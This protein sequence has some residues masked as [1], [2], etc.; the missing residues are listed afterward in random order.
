MT[1]IDSLLENFLV[2]KIPPL[3]STIKKEKSSWFRK[4]CKQA[5]KWMKFGIVFSWDPCRVWYKI[6]SIIT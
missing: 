2:A 3:Y 5:P 4:V 1:L 6:E